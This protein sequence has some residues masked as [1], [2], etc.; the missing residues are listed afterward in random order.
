MVN[1]CVHGSFYALAA[2][3]PHNITGGYRQAGRVKLKSMSC[4][5]CLYVDQCMCYGISN[6][7]IQAGA[8]TSVQR[9]LSGA[10]NHRSNLAA[11][12][13]LVVEML[14]AFAESTFLVI[15]SLLN[16]PAGCSVVFKREAA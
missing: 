1:L 16:A 10:V 3:G 14:T 7:Y 11:T 13:P 8:K 12:L 6:L 5:T 2:V 9:S 4:V 15:N